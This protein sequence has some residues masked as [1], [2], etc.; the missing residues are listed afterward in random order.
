MSKNKL[1]DLK[2]SLEDSGYND[3][4]DTDCISKAV[5]L[6]IKITV[7]GADD[8]DSTNVDGIVMVKENG[9]W[10][11]ADTTLSSMGLR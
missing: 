8:R 6:K 10:K 5:T 2:S 11:F 3:D 9:K 7:K 1:E 4:Y